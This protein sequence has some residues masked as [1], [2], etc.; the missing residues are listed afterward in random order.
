MLRRF[1]GDIPFSGT[2]AFLHSIMLLLVHVHSC[3]P[4]ALPDREVLKPPLCCSFLGAVSTATLNHLN[5]S[6]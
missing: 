5:A 1:C 3:C 2:F 6:F 4:A